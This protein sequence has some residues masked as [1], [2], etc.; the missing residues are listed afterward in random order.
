MSAGIG[1]LYGEEISNLKVT[2]V[3]FFQNKWKWKNCSKMLKDNLLEIHKLSNADEWLF[4]IAV[5]LYQLV[6]IGGICLKFNSQSSL[7]DAHFAEIKATNLVG[8]F[9]FL[10]DNL[11]QKEDL[12]VCNALYYNACSIHV[13]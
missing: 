4:T 12:L 10:L 8:L 13:K 1:M 6:S 7:T 11:Y 9:G 5:I 2:T 3:F